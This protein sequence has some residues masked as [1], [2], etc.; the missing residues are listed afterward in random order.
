MEVT[1][2]MLEMVKKEEIK[3]A[4]DLAEF[5][6]ERWKQVFD[7]LKSQGGR[8]KNLDNRAKKNHAMVSQTLYLFRAKCRGSFQAYEVLQDG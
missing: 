8:I 4:K 2:E 1:K 6:K 3:K 5:T 7:N